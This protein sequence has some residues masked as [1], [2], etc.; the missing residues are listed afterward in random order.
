M[1][2]IDAKVFA[3]IAGLTLALV[4]VLKVF[5][6]KLVTGKE[7]KIALILPIIFTIGAKAAGLFAATE[8]VDAILWAVSGGAASGIGHDK[9][10]DPVKGLIKGLFAKKAVD[11]G[12]VQTPSNDPKS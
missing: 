1:E 9:V 11:P 6:P 12:S 2:S 10:W 5:L 8:W 3:A 7:A 4:E